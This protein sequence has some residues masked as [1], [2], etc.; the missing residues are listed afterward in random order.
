M[1][2]LKRTGSVS[3]F[4]RLLNEALGCGKEGLTLDT[5]G[6]LFDVGY[7]DSSDDEGDAT[8]LDLEDDTTFDNKEENSDVCPERLDPWLYSSTNFLITPPPGS[9]NRRRRGELAL[10]S[11]L[12]NST[13]L[14]ASIRTYKYIK[15]QGL[16]L[17]ITFQTVDEYLQR[18]QL[19]SEAVNIAGSLGLVYLAAA[20]SDFY[21][22]PEKRVLH[23]IQSRDYG[24]QS[25]APTSVSSSLEEEQDVNSTLE[26]PMQLKS[27]NTLNLTLYPVPK[28]IPRIRQKWCPNAFVVSF[29]LETDLSILRQKSVLALQTNDVHLVIGN[30]LASR[31]EKVF[32]LSR[33]GIEDDDS[34]DRVDKN[35][36]I[37]VGRRCDQYGAAELPDGYHVSEV[38]AA[39]GIAEN[40]NKI[41][42]L[43]YATIEYVV[44]R[45]FHYI[46]SDV[47]NCA[48]NP[49]TGQ[50][51]SAAEMAAETTLA[52][53]VNHEKRLQSLYRRLQSERLKARV[54]DLAWNMAGSA[55]GMA[56]SYCIARMM[57]S[58]NHRLSN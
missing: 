47:G 43:E 12:V 15:R 13:T 27:D 19:C 46:S 10:H 51:L 8:V 22:P 40:R 54:F 49:I 52:A 30:E 39:H 57:S 3:P 9:S 24:V 48:V 55:L 37:R 41:D 38:T 36:V 1:I 2:H 5:F 56:M 16:L 50:K 31:Y 34:V 53:R 7:N 28:V 29:K 26:N 17:T 11:R 44:R 23:K 25:M 14:Q 45:H 6:R 20:V 42:S 18:L 4:G 32:I 21:I 58:R 33:G 35:N